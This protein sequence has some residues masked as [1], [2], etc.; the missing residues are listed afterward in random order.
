MLT[1]TFAATAA[2]TAV[3]VRGALGGL[4]VGEQHDPSRRW[5]G[6]ARSGSCALLAMAASEASMPSPMAVAGP[7]CRLLIALCTCSRSVVGLTSTARS[8]RRRPARAAAWPAA[9]STNASAPS[10]AEA[11]RLGVTS[12][13]AMEL[14]TSMASMIVA[15][16]LGTLFS[17]GRS[18]E[19]EDEAGQRQQQQRRRDVAAVPGR[20]ARCDRGSSESCVKRGS[21]DAAGAG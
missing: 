4:P 5:G 1:G 18:G 11:S 17:V 16:S 21:C 3:V 2:C 12:V 14:E 10:F 19:G 6:F 7:S 20:A 9:A 15:R 8:P 13:A